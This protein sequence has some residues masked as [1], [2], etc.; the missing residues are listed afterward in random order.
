MLPPLMCPPHVRWVFLAAR[1]AGSGIVFIGGA[2]ENLCIDAD[3]LEPRRQQ[4]CRAP[5]RD[6]GVIGT[7]M[8]APGGVEP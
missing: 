8:G 2:C 6:G 4:R 3:G 5:D 7:D 1:P